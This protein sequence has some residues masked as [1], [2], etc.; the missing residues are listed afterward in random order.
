LRDVEP[1]SVV[2]TTPLA[3]I[4]DLTQLKL[5][6]SVPEKEITL[7]SQ[8]ETANIETDIYPGKILT[9]KIDYVADRGDDAHNYVVRILLTNTDPATTLKAGMYGTALM[10][11]GLNAQVLVIPRAALLGSAKHPQVFAIENEKAFLTS[12]QTGRS[13]D[14]YVEVLQGLKPGDAV[15]TSGHINL[16]HES[17]VQVVE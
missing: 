14:Q 2:G 15:V 6:I 11:K 17:N 10:K 5:E 4:T 3:R 13:N 7:F 1:G 16:S 9:G 12:I 8:G